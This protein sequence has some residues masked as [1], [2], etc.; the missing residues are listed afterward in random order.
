MFEVFAT[1]AVPIYV[2]MVDSCSGC[3]LCVAYCMLYIVC[4]ILYIVCCVLYI[5]CYMLYIAFDVSK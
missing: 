5:V 4:Y 1:A 3:V 2:E